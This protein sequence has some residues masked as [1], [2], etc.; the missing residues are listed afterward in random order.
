MG[1][2]LGGRHAG[3]EGGGGV[4]AGVGPVGVVGAAADVQREFGSE[5][6]GLLRVVDGAGGLAAVAADHFVGPGVEQ[7]LGGVE[8]VALLGRPRAVGTQAIHD[9]GPAAG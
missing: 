1:A 2:V 4:V 6:G 5:G 7:Q 9:A 8:A 3:L